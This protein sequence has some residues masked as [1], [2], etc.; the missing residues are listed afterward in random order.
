MSVDFYQANV[1]CRT[2]CISY[3]K[4][5]HQK[6]NHTY[7]WIQHSFFYSVELIYGKDDNNILP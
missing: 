1:Q 4:Y 7:E 6:E 2:Y 3:I 5:V